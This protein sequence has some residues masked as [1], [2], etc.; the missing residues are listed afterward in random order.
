MAISATGAG[1]VVQKERKH[2]SEARVLL[3]S[4]GKLLIYKKRPERMSGAFFRYGASSFTS[5]L[6]AFGYFSASKASIFLS[7]AM[8]LTFIACIS[9][10]YVVLFWRAAALI[11]ICHTERK[12]RFFSFLLV[13]ACV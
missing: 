9:C 3:L 6:N 10:E 11:L 12:S 8:L 13:Y 4:V 7:N 2:C 5:A 1:K